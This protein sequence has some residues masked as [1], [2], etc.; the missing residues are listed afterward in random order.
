M[1]FCFCVSFCYLILFYLVSTN[2][3][4]VWFSIWWFDVIGAILWDNK[5][6][7]QQQRWRRSPNFRYAYERTRWQNEIPNIKITNT[8]QTHKHTHTIDMSNGIHV[9]HGE[10][11]WNLGSAQCCVNICVVYCFFARLHDLRLSFNSVCVCVCVFIFFLARFHT[12]FISLLK[13]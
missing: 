7:I 6:K 12:Q 4:S 8:E 11:D 9:L 2:F 1:E 10:Y 13:W 3:L 5:Q